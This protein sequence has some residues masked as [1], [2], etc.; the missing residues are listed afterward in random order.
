VLDRKDC[1]VATLRPSAVGTKAQ[2]Q[3]IKCS[4]GEVLINS[5]SKKDE[6]TEWQHCNW[7]KMSKEI[8]HHVRNVGYVT[9]RV[10]LYFTSSMCISLEVV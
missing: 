10:A 6:Y 8:E 5:R 7:F 1:L 2:W 9:V 3:N 4:A